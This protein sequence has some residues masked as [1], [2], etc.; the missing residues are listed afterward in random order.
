MAMA[1]MAAMATMRRFLVSS[2]LVLG[3]CVPLLPHDYFRPSAAEGTSPRNHCWKTFENL[4]VRRGPGDVTIHVVEPG[5]GRAF[6]A[7]M[8]ELPE[9]HRARVERADFEMVGA[10]GVHRRVAFDGVAPD[11]RIDGTRLPI[12]RTL[13]GST[14]RSGSTAIP[15]N[16]WLYAPI[17]V[18]GREDFTV[19]L[20]AIA[21]DGVREPLPVVRFTRTT[22]V[23]PIAPLQ[24]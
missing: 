8:F 23:Q 18:A 9:G 3:G 2:L 15:R 12:D 10:S 4:V 1:A 5:G 17:D 24:C 22:E 14:W 21:F 13:E 7:V 20:P 19:A 11:E 16:Y 6:V